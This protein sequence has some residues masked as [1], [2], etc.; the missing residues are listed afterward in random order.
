[1]LHLHPARM[2][3]V[4]LVIIAGQ[5]HRRRMTG[6][7]QLWCMMM[8]AAM[9]RRSIAEQ[10]PR[11]LVRTMEMHAAGGRTSAAAE[12]IQGTGAQC[13][14]RMIATAATETTA[15]GRDGAAVPTTMSGRFIAGWQ[16]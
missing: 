7:A 3:P 6:G 5:L 9:V 4:H 13:S 1:M 11:F 14:G 10:I 8:S 16:R 15:A 12:L 2:I